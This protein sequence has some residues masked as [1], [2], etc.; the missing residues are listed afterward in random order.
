[1]AYAE[2]GES[3]RFSS[4]LTFVAR[5]VCADFY[6]RLHFFFFAVFQSNVYV[7][8]L[9][10]I[11]AQA[12]AIRSER[13]TIPRSWDSCWSD[14]IQQCWD[15]NPS[16]R[17]GFDVIILKLEQYSHDVLNT[18]YDTVAVADVGKNR[19]RCTIS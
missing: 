9:Q 16:N 5:F 2:R 4:H 7:F 19:C 12:A 8:R 17:P 15:E 14:L 6:L 18:E 1:M 13:P 3:P 11:A 10:L